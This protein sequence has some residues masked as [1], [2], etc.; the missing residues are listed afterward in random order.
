MNFR[1]TTFYVRKKYFYKFLKKERKPFNSSSF[2]TFVAQIDQFQ[3]RP[4]DVFIQKIQEDLFLSPF[5]VNR[6]NY[7]SQPIL[8]QN[9]DCAEKITVASVN[10]PS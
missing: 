5:F 3:V 4:C 9:V 1:L 10:L 8:P 6:K 7:E 2:G